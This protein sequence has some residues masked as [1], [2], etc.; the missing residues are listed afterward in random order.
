M[1]GNFSF[2]NYFKKEAIS[3]TLGILVTEVLELDKSK[4][5]VTIYPDDKEAY[6]YW[7]NMIGLADERIFKFDDNFWEIGEGPCGPDSE[8][9][10]DLALNAAVASLR[11]TSAVTATVTWKFGTRFHPVQPDER[12]KIRTL[13]R[14]TSI[15]AAASNDWL[16]SFSRRNRTLKQT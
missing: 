9:F 10:Y 13:E 5:Y 11:A 1:L 12:R 6:D 14:K 2:G 7:H 8:I 15:P 4:L 3:Q 16:R